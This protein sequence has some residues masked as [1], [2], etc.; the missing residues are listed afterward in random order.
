MVWHVRR[1]ATANAEARQLAESERRMRDA[2]RRFVRFASHE[3]RTPL[4]V[5]RGY[6]ELIRAE[7]LRPQVGDDAVVVLEELDK[8]ERIAARLLMLA[9]AG[10]P[11]GLRTGPVD[12]DALLQRTVK[13]WRPIAERRW[14]IDS[15]T[16][17]VV[18]DPERLEVALDSLLENA[19]RFTDGGGTIGIRAHNDGVSVIIEVRDDGL[20]IPE[21]DL[22]FVFEGFHSGSERGGTGI[23]LAIVAAVVESHGG[24]VHAA[25]IA[26]GGAVFTLRLPTST[27]A[28]HLGPMPPRHRP[29]IL[30]PP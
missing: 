17:T 7:D 14:L 9:Q 1:R 21:A 6:T 23:G 8:L 16:G 26:G 22:P 2:Q 29:A 25:N 15:N 5:A 18:C 11:S 12:L 3:L 10:E 24:T 30:A 19:V 4:T 27:N 28:A 13:R 20:G